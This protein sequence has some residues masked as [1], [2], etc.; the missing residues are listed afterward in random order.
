MAENNLIVYKVQVD[1]AS[2]K[3]AIEGL[4]N[5][6]VKASTAVTKLKKEMDTLATSAQGVGTS[7]GIAG[8]FIN[9][10]GRTISDLP[11]GIQ[12]ISN[13]ISQLGSL[14]AVMVVS[15]G[16]LTD[17]MKSLLATL[18]SSPILLGLLAFQAI[19]A[20]ITYFDKQASKATKTID[21]FNKSL[22]G[23]NGNIAQIEK[24][25]RI[26]KDSTSSIE[27]QEYALRQL[28][29]EG[30]DKLKGSLDDFLK[31]KKAILL[32]DIKE[33]F[34]KDEAQKL[35]EKEIELQGKL[36]EANEKRDK[37]IQNILKK[38]S[39]TQS[40][41]SNDILYATREAAEATGEIKDEISGVQ[42]EIENLINQ[43][44]SQTNKL[45]DDLGGNPFFDSLTGGDEDAQKKRKRL[46]K[47]NLLD[48]NNEIESLN[49]DSEVKAVEFEEDK[50][51]RDVKYTKL[52]IENEYALFLE[53]EKIRYLDALGEAKTSD[54]KIQIEETWD[55]TK[56][57]AKVAL[58]EALTALDS[59]TASK[60]EVIEQNKQARIRSIIMQAMGDEAAFKIQMATNDFDRIAGE[61][62]AQKI[63]HE[64][65][66]GLLDEE[67]QARIDAGYE[68]SEVDA[69]I[70]DEKN[71][72]AYK[73]AQ[74]QRKLELS[75]LD[76]I[77][78]VG[79]AA[80]DIAGEGSAVG[81][82]VA[83]AM[84]IMNTR[85]A[86]TAALGSKPYGPWNIAQAVAVGAAGFA[87]VKGIINQP[88][89]VA[90]KS[91]SGSAPSV[92]AP[93]FNIV[94]ANSSNQL[95]S[96]IQGQFN[97]PIKAYVVAKDVSTAQELDRNVVNA[98]SIG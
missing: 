67:R 66:M 31:A 46:F 14:F 51:K 81:K 60:Q 88:V 2:G 78:Q 32:F 86:I 62:D 20:A 23:V 53:K 54:E 59:S 92:Q 26:L 85:E 48:F 80:I 42:K 45:V 55:K 95:A 28:K 5:G 94:G 89:P 8:A 76:V 43:S 64:T 69:K 71:N 3:V 83:I 49:R 98:A 10:F 56:K 37:R 68:T 30:Y 35:M 19:T 58:G 39:I 63:A 61:L 70:N 40:Q 1:A 79:Q 82:A 18:K 97:N 52:R 7:S 29:K 22:S 13:N 9:E 16:G 6:F 11:Y 36:A 90:G 87:Q 41:K 73:T 77:R 75:K 25:A 50:L 27:R 24:Y 91:S 84:A 74:I 33:K 72:N 12:A 4:T 96:A 21:D 65:R 38:T 57:Q 34:I 15:A 44:L 17:A 47:Q 93:D